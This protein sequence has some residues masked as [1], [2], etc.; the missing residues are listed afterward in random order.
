MTYLFVGE[1]FV[2][3]NFEFSHAFRCKNTDEASEL[4][5]HEIDYRFTNE[6]K[7]TKDIDYKIYKFGQ[8]KESYVVDCRYEKIIYKRERKDFI[9]MFE[10]GEIKVDM[11][12]QNYPSLHFMDTLRSEECKELF[13]VMKKYY[14]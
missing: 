1:V 12:Q 4:M 8:D 3:G 6:T 13:E 5:K 14:D 7:G 11:W 9:F 2:N 10:A